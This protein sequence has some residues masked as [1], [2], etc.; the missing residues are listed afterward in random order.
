MRI[1]FFLCIVFGLIS[2]EKKTDQKEYEP[3]VISEV[4]DAY[5]KARKNPERDENG[6]ILP[7]PPHREKWGYGYEN[8]IIDDSLNVFYYEFQ[9][10]FTESCIPEYEDSIPYLQGLRP[11]W[12]IQLPKESLTEF[13]KLN[14]KRGI[15]NKVKIAS[16][17]DTLSS[18][19]YFDLM[20]AFDKYLDWDEN[21]DRDIYAIFATTQEEDTV[22]YYKKNKKAYYTDSIKWD[23][24]RI[25]F[26]KPKID[27]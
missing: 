15:R 12:L 19:E 7:P 5:Q 21:G 14:F 25:R 26:P 11:D 22:L 9:P 4:W 8:F 3:Y 1:L 16:Q 24:K 27:E 13:V 23:K 10:Q 2:C 6:N 17:K 18:K 20:K